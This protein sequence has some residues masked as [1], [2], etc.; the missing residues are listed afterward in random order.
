MKRCPFLLAITLGIVLL[1]SSA[2]A[3]VPAPSPTRL[4]T[5]APASAIPLTITAPRA[6]EI[7]TAGQMYRVTWNAAPQIARVWI[8]YSECPTCLTWIAPNVPNTGA[9]TWHVCAAN[10]RGS[11]FKLIVVGYQ[12]GVA[13]VTAR[14]DGA[15]TIARNPQ[16]PH[17]AQGNGCSYSTYLPLL[18]R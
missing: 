5:T 15:F 14:S 2:T 11:Q 1:V 17:V 9:Y 3:S 16:T 6:G 18:T 8:G 12:P 13:S 10:A 7:L 4:P